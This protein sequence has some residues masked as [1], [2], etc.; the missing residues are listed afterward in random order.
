M[1]ALSVIVPYC[2]GYFLSQIE[3]DGLRFDRIEYKLKRRQTRYDTTKG[4]DEAE[5]LPKFST[6]SAWPPDKVLV[7]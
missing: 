4:T 3:G 1:L 5:A 2:S 7:K 6:K